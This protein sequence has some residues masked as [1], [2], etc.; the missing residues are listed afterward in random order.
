MTGLSYSRFG[1]Y[2]CL[3]DDTYVENPERYIYQDFFQFIVSVILLLIVIVVM[4]DLFAVIYA[5]SNS[6]HSYI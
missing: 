4:M 3:W 6:V 2:H 5:L 1:D